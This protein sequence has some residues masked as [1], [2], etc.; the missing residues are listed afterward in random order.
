MQKSVLSEIIRSLSK[1]EI[2]ELHKWLQSP[3]HNQRQDVVRLFD[4]LVKTLTNGDEAAEKER[5]WKAVF[6]KQPYDDAYMR[7]VMYFLL[8]AVEDYLA[9]KEFSN[10]KVQH[11]LTLAKIYRE[12]KLEKAYRQAYRIGKDALENQPLRDN[13]YLRHKFFFEQDFGQLSNVVQNASANLQETADALEK[14][15]LAEKLH[16]SYAMLAHKSVYKTV[17]YTDG[18][19]ADTLQYCQ[20]DFFLKEPAI[21]LYYYAYMISTNPENEQYFDE[22]EELIHK[23]NSQFHQSEMRTLYVAALNYCIGRANI[24]KT[25]YSRRLFNLYCGGLQ[26]GYLLEGELVSRYTFGN[27]VGAALRLKEFGWAEKFIQDFQHHLDEKERNSIVN[28]NQSRIYFEKGDYTRAQQLLTQFEY[29]DMLF[30]LIAKTMLLKIYYETDE[31]DAFESLLESMRTYL[32]RK[33]ALD[34]TRKAA[35][36]NM[37]SLMKK[38]LSLNIFSKPQKDAF[39]EL[40]LKTNPLAEREWLLRQL[41]EK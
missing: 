29:D 2:R 14:W 1:K 21:S 5:A 7:Q 13:Y 37:I 41:G 20:N 26:A 40:V 34:P 16:I 15:F 32:Q 18:I 39:R 19:L 8:K 27:A 4:F 35:Y 24:G 30:N 6:P 25:E 31:Y 22:F 3:A 10:D 9:F 38:L 36:K 28:F 12:R 23:S 33:E 11:Q 17:T